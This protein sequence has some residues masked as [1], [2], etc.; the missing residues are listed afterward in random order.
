MNKLTVPQDLGGAPAAIKPTHP[1]QDEE[2]TLES[3]EKTL[4]AA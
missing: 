2:T 3:V 1:E 4:S